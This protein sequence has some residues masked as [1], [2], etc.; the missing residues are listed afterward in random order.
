MSNIMIVESA[1]KIEKIKSFL[2]AGWQVYASYGH[3]RD[4]E[5]N[6]LG[7]NPPDFKAR[8]V[9][10]DRGSD[11]VSR[12][13]S[14]I[15]QG[16]TIYLATDPDREGEAIAWHLKESLGLDDPHRI[17]FSEITKNAVQQA[18]NN[19]RK[20]NLF[21]VAAQQARRLLD[22]AVGFQVSPALSNAAG[23]TLSAGRVQ[24]PA[25]RL[26]VERE[27]SIRAFKP[28]AH[29][30]AMIFFNQDDPSADKWFMEWDTAAWLNK[31]P[32][33]PI[34]PYILDGEL[35]GNIANIKQ[36]TVTKFENKISKRSPPAPFTTST[37]QQ[38]AS[39]QLKLKPARTMEL[40]QSL[41]EAG[42]ISYM[43]TDSPNLSDEAIQDIFN[44][45]QMQNLPLA[46]QPRKW[47]SK[48]NAQEA[49]EAIRPTD[50]NQKNISLN[51][52]AESLYQLIWNRAVASQLADAEYNVR[53]IKATS[54]YG[55][56][57]A[58][59]DGKSRAIAKQ[60]WLCITQGDA[61][62]ENPE[63]WAVNPIPV[64]A[65]NST[66]NVVKGVVTNK[67]TKAPS[68]YT[69][70][71]LT[72]ELERLGIGRPSTYV[73]IMQTL[74]DRNY[75]NEQKRQLYATDK[76]EMVVKYLKEK[77]QFLDY[78]FTSNI[79]TTLDELANNRAKYKPTMNNFY[80]GLLKE[81]SDFD[82]A[83]KLI[84]P[85]HPC[86]SCGLALKQIKI[87]DNKPFWGCTGHPTCKQTMDDK[88]GLPVAKVIKEVV[89]S[90]F[91]CTKCGSG[92]IFR[93]GKTK[94]TSK[95]KA[96]EYKFWGCSN[97]P[98][99]DGKFNDHNGSPNFDEK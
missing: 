87:K 17:T 69:E 1:G 23:Q 49:H 55:N 95:K 30:S 86:P 18:V 68:R 84:P 58:Q 70:A 40:A 20:I 3:I 25:L 79:E 8:Y 14:K 98:K 19:P 93:Q 39:V 15:K 7:L 80:D 81:L 72:K 74:H 91:K 26:M 90:D 57:I 52:E 61:T 2:G 99:C 63:Q 22:R 12:L 4:L 50:V 10:T 89:I 32:N 21:L 46:S 6:D 83:I 47:Q 54:T 75:I 42:H 11:V 60:G 94:A 28:T 73:S 34:S 27:Q 67:T 5:K 36:V 48:D 92:L 77:F 97:F 82:Q 53:V 13:K 29:F 45:A 96:G 16:D 62:E 24:S 9:F 51:Q 43:R 85:K 78:S 38:A 44:Y 31:Y 76:G 33:T 56:K 65:E 35:A 59:W 66:Q 71:S 64:I 41:Y 88:N 37:L